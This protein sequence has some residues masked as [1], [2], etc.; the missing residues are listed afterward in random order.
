MTIADEGLLEKTRC[1]HLPGCEGYRGREL[2]D[3]LYNGGV[4]VIS[5]NGRGGR[6]PAAG[7]VPPLGYA[8]ILAEGRAG[9]V[10]LVALGEAL[11]GGM[12][13]SASGAEHCGVALT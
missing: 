8:S 4:R 13:I 3:S 6:W 7:V 2:K 12:G 5:R 1:Q 9:L 10:H 11:G